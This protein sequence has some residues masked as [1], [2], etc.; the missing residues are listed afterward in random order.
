M[1]NIWADHAFRQRRKSVKSYFRLVFNKSQF[2]APALLDLRVNAAF[3]V[4]RYCHF[5]DKAR[6]YAHE[7]LS[8]YILHRDYINTR[9][10]L[11]VSSRGSKRN[12]FWIQC[13]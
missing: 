2:D 10:N 6:V 1:A 5:W 4:I 11:Q 7:Q 13:I 12:S 8:I 9:I 3:A